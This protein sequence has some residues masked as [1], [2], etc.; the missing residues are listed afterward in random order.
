MTITV[1]FRPKNMYATIL[2]QGLAFQSYLQLLNKRLC[3]DIE[4]ANKNYEK[5]LDRN[6]FVAQKASNF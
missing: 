4:V 6:Y 5:K 3:L 2:S 1:S